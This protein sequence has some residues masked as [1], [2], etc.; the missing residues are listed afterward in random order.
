LTLR[1]KTLGQWR[2]FGE[3]T[4]PGLE[5]Q[6]ARRLGGSFVSL[7]YAGAI[8]R[9][10][11]CLVPPGC[12]GLE[13]APIEDLVGFFPIERGLLKDAGKRAA[14][15][16]HGYKRPF[17]LAV[18]ADLLERDRLHSGPKTNLEVTQMALDIG[19]ANTA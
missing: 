18:F 9:L 14:G 3:V 19:I 17:G 8:R 2:C 5:T 12:G 6:I 1:R 7:P 4:G 11:V 15:A 13:I 10:I 16:P